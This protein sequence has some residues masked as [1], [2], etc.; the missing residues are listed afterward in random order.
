MI[1]GKASLKRNGWIV[2]QL[3]KIPCQFNLKTVEELL[4][5]NKINKGSAE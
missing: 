2:G 5:R 1:Y 3:S 4:Q